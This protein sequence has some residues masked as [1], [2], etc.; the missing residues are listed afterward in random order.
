[1]N[2]V[3]GHCINGNKL[4]TLRNGGRL[5]RWHACI[6]ALQTHT[7]WLHVP[8]SDCFLFKSNL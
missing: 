6:R 7:D 8:R 3:R 5:R 4:V 1:M 2:G